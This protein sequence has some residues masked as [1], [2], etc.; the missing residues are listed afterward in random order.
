MAT[1]ISLPVARA[2]ITASSITLDEEN[3]E[4]TVIQSF[5]EKYPDSRIYLDYKL[6]KKKTALLALF[7]LFT[8]WLSCLDYL[9][10]SVL[11]RHSV[12]RIGDFFV[13]VFFDCFLCCS[14]LF[15]CLLISSWYFNL[16]LARSITIPILSPSPLV[17]VLYSCCVN[18]I[19]C[20]CA[21]SIV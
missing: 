14:W 19:V 9:I 2:G 21:I 15:H 7:L 17:L 3:T 16:Q 12:E 18:S 6:Y 1:I 5:Q 10:D 13:L 4:T 20:C 11:H 8:L